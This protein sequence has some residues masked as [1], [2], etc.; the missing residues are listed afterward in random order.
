M[1]STRTYKT[2]ADANVQYGVCLSSV[3]ESISYIVWTT[4]S[5]ESA[6]NA[7]TFSPDGTAFSNGS[8]KNA[9]C[10]YVA[11]DAD[12]AA[13]THGVTLSAYCSNAIKTQETIANLI[14]EAP[15]AAKSNGTIPFDASTGEP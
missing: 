3:P 8:S 1:G 2:A 4:C 11:V 14:D 5:N 10:S 6:V 7:S 12:I 13:N 9:H 15:Q